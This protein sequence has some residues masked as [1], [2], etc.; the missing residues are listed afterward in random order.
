MKQIAEIGFI[1]GGFGSNDYQV[2]K[3]C[4]KLS[5]DRGYEHRGLSFRAH[6]ANPEKAAE[7]IDGATV[8]THSAGALALSRTVRHYPKVT[9]RQV[10]MVAPP[11]PDSSYRLVLKTQKIAQ[12]EFADSCR[13]RS[14]LRHNTSHA[15]ATVRELGRHAWGNFGMIPHIARFDSV[16]F[17]SELAER[18]IMT[19][20]V[21]G[22]QD[23]FF[24]PYSVSFRTAMQRRSPKLD[25]KIIESRHCDFV[26]NPQAAL[27]KIALADTYRI[28]TLD[29]FAEP[30]PVSMYEPI[31]A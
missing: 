4:E 13:D 9:P 23:E 10:T 1:S 29:S 24:S 31:L 26:L 7:L 18:N 16:Y 27:A 20:V 17:G 14:A 19:E 28:S 22:D 5:N 3:V 30:V 8:I 6:I 12:N 21:F 2:N 15:A 25:V 11:I